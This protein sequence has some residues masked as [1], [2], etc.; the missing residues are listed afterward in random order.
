V[1]KSRP[2][3]SDIADATD[4]VCDDDERGAVRDTIGLGWKEHLRNEIVGT[5]SR[6]LVCDLRLI[7]IEVLIQYSDRYSGIGLHRSFGS[8]SS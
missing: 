3:D 5:G 8:R 2:T 6:Y 7:R 4:L 1:Y